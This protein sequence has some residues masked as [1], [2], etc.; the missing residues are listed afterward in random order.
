LWLCGEAHRSFPGRPPSL[1]LKIYVKNL[2]TTLAFLVMEGAR[3]AAREEDING[4]LQ[5]TLLV[6]YI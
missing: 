3:K 2:L 4:F 1:C 6:I 5:L